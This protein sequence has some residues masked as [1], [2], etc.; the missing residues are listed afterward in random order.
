[1]LFSYGKSM[2]STAVKYFTFQVNASAILFFIVLIKP[3]STD[4]IE[5]FFS[6]LILAKLGIAPSHVWFTSVLSSLDWAAFLWVSIPQKLIPLFILS[7][8]LEISWF[9]TILLISVLV[10]TLHAI[11]QLKI[12]KVLAASSVF[13]LNWISIA[14]ITSTSGWVL[15]F[16][17]YRATTLVVVVSY[18]YH[19]G[20]TWSSNSYTGLIVTLAIIAL[21]GVPPRP[22]FFIKI[23][24]FVSRV[25]QNLLTVSSVAMLASLVI[26]YIYINTVLQVMLVSPSTKPLSQVVNTGQYYYM[27]MAIL[28][29]SLLMLIVN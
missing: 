4:H 14:M 20:L 16:T 13:S 29:A 7:L 18:L 23:D 10:S 26:L 22:L 15:F 12:K 3:Y 1:M 28:F 11:S 27:L 2:K 9:L 24:L 25:Q 19:S 5:A 17:L 6:V 8:T 21:A